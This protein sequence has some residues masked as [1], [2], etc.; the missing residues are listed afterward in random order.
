MPYKLI[1]LVFQLVKLICMYIPCREGKVL[2]AAS[3]NAD[4]VVARTAELLYQDKMPPAS[5]LR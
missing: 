3:L 5:D 2:A 4:P 1:Y